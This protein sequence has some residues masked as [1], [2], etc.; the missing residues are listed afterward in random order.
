MLIYNLIS[1]Q[2][3]NNYYKPQIL[4][5]PHKLI[6]DKLGDVCDQELF[7]EHP[8]SGENP[9]IVAYLDK[10]ET[11]NALGPRDSKNNKVC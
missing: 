3:H 10:M 11:A 6:G 5:S 7:E 8:I 2:N 1:E 9:Q 4:S